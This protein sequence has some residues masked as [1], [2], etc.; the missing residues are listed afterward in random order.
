MAP[1]FTVD[2]ASQVA[3]VV[4]ITS[5]AAAVNVPVWQ[6][7]HTRF[8]D[9]VPSTDTCSPGWHTAHTVHVAAFCAV[10]NLPAGQDEQVRSDAAVELDVSCWPG[11]QTVVFEHTRSVLGVGGATVCSPSTQ[12]AKCA[13]HWLWSRV[14]EK[15]PARQ[16]A[17]TTSA[18]LVACCLT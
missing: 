15:V 11:R 16:A 10:E 18:E 8:C 4:Q 5:L 12:A 7:R 14:S 3:C 1:P 13:L 2:P 6:A 17:H 9:G